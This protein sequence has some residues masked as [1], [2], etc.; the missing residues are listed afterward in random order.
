MHADAQHGDPLMRVGVHACLCVSP[1]GN[2]SLENAVNWLAE[3]G[4]DADIDEP[5]EV[6]P[7][8]VKVVRASSSSASLSRLPWILLLLRRRW[9]ARGMLPSR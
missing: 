8:S 1:A 3:H 6:D 5:L 9:I 7:A 4:E 2:D